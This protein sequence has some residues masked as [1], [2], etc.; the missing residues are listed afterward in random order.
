LLS[1]SLTAVLA[2]APL[3]FA[4]D[5]TGAEVQAETNKAQE[6]ANAEV[7][8]A[9]EQVKLT[10]ALA[11]NDFAKARE[12]YR[13]KRQ[14]DIDAL[15]RKL[16]ELDDKS[17]KATRKTKK[18]L[19]ATVASPRAETDALGKDGHSPCSRRARP[20]AARAT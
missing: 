11:Q 17:S 10:S 6:Q 16:D 5:K 3:A 8:K 2:L 7:A 20:R 14:G 19:G 9:E 12:D 15:N 18:D 4:C 13:H 1:T